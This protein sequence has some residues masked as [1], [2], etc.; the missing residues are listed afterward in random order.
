V[1]AA[2]TAAAEA[3]LNSQHYV[4]AVLGASLLVGVQR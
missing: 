3:A 2:A 4:D 1:Y